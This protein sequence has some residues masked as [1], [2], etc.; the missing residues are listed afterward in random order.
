[1]YETGRHKGR[2]RAK[3]DADRHA[4]VIKA[5][6]KGYLIPRNPCI[7]AGGGWNVADVLRMR[8][9]ATPYAPIAGHG[10]KIGPEP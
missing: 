10:G 8:A 4:M 6:A 7:P 9:I 1:M 2:Q 5:R 3:A